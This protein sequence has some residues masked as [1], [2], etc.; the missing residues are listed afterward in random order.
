[1][2]LM[3]SKDVWNV[4]ECGLEIDESGYQSVT[5][6]FGSYRLVSKNGSSGGERGSCLQ[7]LATLTGYTIPRLAYKTQ[8]L[9]VKDL[10]YVISSAKDLVATGRKKSYQHALNSLLYFPK[11]NGKIKEI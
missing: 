10:Y 9:K 3:K 4:K 2:E 7:Q 1:M 11:E 6:L 5:D 8:H